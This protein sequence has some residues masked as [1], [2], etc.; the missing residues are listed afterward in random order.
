[1][2]RRGPEVHG[3]R[4]GVISG[5]GV[6]PAAEARS[7]QLRAVWEPK[8]QVGRGGGP[9]VLPDAEDESQ[10]SGSYSGTRCTPVFDLRRIDYR[11]VQGHN[12]PIGAYIAITASRWTPSL[13]LTFQA[14]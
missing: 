14:G 11:D 5:A 1:M 8:M 10:A 13:M 3:E 2:A 7:G 6:P 12:R 9:Q 4:P